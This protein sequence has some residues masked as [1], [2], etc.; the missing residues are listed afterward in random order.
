VALRPGQAAALPLGEAVWL[1]LAFAVVA[2]GVYAPALQGPFVSDDLHYVATNPYVQALSFENVRQILDPWGPASVFVVN[3]TPVHLLLHAVQWSLFGPTVTGYHVTNVLLHA[4]GSVLLV[5]LFRASG[6]RRVGAILG[7]ALFLLHPVNVEAVAWIS[8]LKSSACFVLSAATLLAFPASPALATPLFFLALL[9][10][11]TASFL[12]PVAAVLVWVRLSRERTPVRHWV[13]LGLWTAGFLL[14]AVAQIEVN[15]RSG[16]PDAGLAAEGL[17]RLRTVAAIAL[18]Y[19]VMS[20]TSLGVSA[21][22]E[23]E[24]TIA[25][26]DPWFLAAIPTLALGAVRAFSSLRRRR[27]EAVYWVWAAASF[28]PVSQIFPFLYPMADRY[29]YFILPGLLGAVLLALQDLL[30]TL[31]PRLRERA[32]RAG[33]ALGAALCLV[34]G[35]RSHARAEIWRTPALLLVDAARN[36]PEGV[37]ANLLRAKRAAQEGDAKRAVAA[38]RAAQARG[39]NRFEQLQGDPAYDPIRSDPAFRALVRDVAAWWIARADRLEN[40]TQLELRQRALA[41][42]ARGENADAVAWLKAA[43]ARGGPIDARIRGE[44]EEVRRLGAAQP[45]LPPEP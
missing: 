3:Y 40:P 45:L 22:H 24:R 32:P 39:Y 37:A 13:W 17:A 18:R 29:L 26:S 25:A 35:L 30:G 9:A 5:A 43:L 27:E 28:A 2:L 8:Q 19:V 1:F 38:L 42:L 11:P 12:L 23:P 4:L 20:A 33:V 16:T 44:L 34:F 7:G 41:H 14:L 31:S 6:V 36:Y 15:R 21:F 10:K